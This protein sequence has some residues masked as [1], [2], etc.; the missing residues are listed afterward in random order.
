VALPATRPLRRRDLIRFDLTTGLWVSIRQL[1]AHLGARRLVQVAWGLARR[2]GQDPLH[3]QQTPAWAETAEPL[4]RH[5][6]RPALQLDEVLADDLGLSVEERLPILRAVIAETGAAF[7]ATHAKGVSPRAWAR[8]T[9]PARQGWA[10]GLIGRFFNA[11]IQGVETT[12]NTIRFQVSACRFASLVVALDRPHLAPL[13]CAADSVFFERPGT[14]ATLT[15]HGTLAQ[16][17]PACD[18]LLALKPP[19]P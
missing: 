13:F 12:E 19:E 17:A 7:V 14:P 11:R 15:R 18:F 8:A 4:V 16:G 1:A 9:V 10:E 2:T 5:Q 3:G 6:L